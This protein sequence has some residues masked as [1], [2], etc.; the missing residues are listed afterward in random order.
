MARAPRPRRPLPPDD[1]GGAG[2]PAVVALACLLIVLLAAAA[3]AAPAVESD[4]PHAAPKLYTRLFECPPT[5]APRACLP[6]PARPAR[7]TAACPLPGSLFDAAPPAARHRPDGPSAPSAP[8]PVPAAAA[9]LGT[10]LAA[11]ALLKR[12]Q[13]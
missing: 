8:V 10:A 4:G 7:R 5:E 3:F 6:P 13:R 9:S 2:G 12:R 11:L 1:E